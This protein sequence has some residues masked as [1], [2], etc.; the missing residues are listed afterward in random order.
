MDRIDIQIEVPPVKYQ[1]LLNDSK[2]EDSRTIRERVMRARN[3]QKERFVNSGIYCNAHMFPR[4]IRQYCETDAEG[5]KLLQLAM[6]RLGLSARAHD[7]ILKVART[8]ADLEGNA[9]IQ[10]SHISEGVSYRSLDRELKY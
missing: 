3:I 6:T 10:P 5:K 1:E 7:R 9:R 8:I 2:G 4:Q